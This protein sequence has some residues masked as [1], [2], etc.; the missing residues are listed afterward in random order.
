[1]M[2]R[3]LGQIILA[4]VFLMSLTAVRVWQMTRLAVY[5]SSLVNTQTVDQGEL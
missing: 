3:R 5:E 1:M 4:C 2:I